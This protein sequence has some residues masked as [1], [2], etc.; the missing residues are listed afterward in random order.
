MKENGNIKDPELE[1]IIELFQYQIFR[2]K[3]TA[4]LLYRQLQREL[5]HQHQTLETLEKKGQPGAIQVKESMVQ[6]FKYQNVLNSLSEPIRELTNAVH[7]LA[8]FESL[9]LEELEQLHNQISSFSEQL[10]QIQLK[11]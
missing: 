3:R 5:N 7:H 2:L 8:F 4:H 9:S 10:K 1:K 6:V 11:G